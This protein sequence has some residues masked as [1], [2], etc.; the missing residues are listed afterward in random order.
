MKKSIIEL[1]SLD[2]SAQAV[3]GLEK[4]LAKKLLE[5][6]SSQRNTVARDTYGSLGECYGADEAPQ[7][8]E[9]ADNAY[10]IFYANALKKFGVNG[11]Q[12]FQDENTKQQFFNY[13]DQNWK[14]QDAVQQQQVPGMGAQ[15]SMQVGQPAMQGTPA[16]GQQQVP[17]VSGQNVEAGTQTQLPA[18][19]A[20]PMAPQNGQSPQG[21]GNQQMPMS[22]A[23]DPSVATMAPAGPAIDKTA[24]MGADG[25]D[26]DLDGIQNT[27]AMGGTDQ[28]GNGDDDSD[29]D[30]EIG[31]EDQDQNQ[32][33]QNGFDNPDDENGFDMSGD[34][35]DEGDEDVPNKLSGGNDQDDDD[36]DQDQN[37]NSDDDDE[38]GDDDAY[39][40]DHSDFLPKNDDGDED[41]QDQ[42]D[43]SEDD[44]DDDDHPDDDNV[45]SSDDGNGQDEED[46]DKDPD[47]E[48]GNDDDDSDEDEN[49]KFASKKKKSFGESLKPSDRSGKTRKKDSAKATRLDGKKQTKVYEGD[50]EVED[51]VTFGEEYAADNAEDERYLIERLNFFNHAKR[52]LKT[53]P[54]IS[55]EERSMKLQGIN[56]GAKKHGMVKN[57]LRKVE[58]LR[59]M[60]SKQIKKHY[61]AIKN[62]Q[63]MSPEHRHAAREK[64]AQLHKQNR[65]H[66]RSLALGIKGIHTGRLSEDFMVIHPSGLSKVQITEENGVF[67]SRMFINGGETATN[68]TSTHKTLGG[69]TKWAEATMKHHHGA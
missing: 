15:P 48:I 22:G 9:P 27:Q 42:D 14:A 23:N 39:S 61:A 17:G 68:A 7:F 59:D 25:D 5:A 32:N 49:P 47:L 67:N 1:I 16:P 13:L 33:G 44:L 46:D 19:A 50:G 54:N 8:M 21:M 60:A 29:I 51:G 28:F 34:N 38:F 66:F 57:E 6:I 2:E 26:E 62:D 11:P 18:P 52:S 12:D 10:Q 30:L 36:Q 64:L 43:D 20:Q 69:A 31:D 58:N 37:G 4:T 63:S 53:D 56:S 24:P 35:G 45:D 41:D 55:P 65:N 3:S 40:V